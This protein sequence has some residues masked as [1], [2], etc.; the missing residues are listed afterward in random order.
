[1]NIYHVKMLIFNFL[2]NILVSPHNEN[3]LNNHYNVSLIQNHT[4]RTTIKSRL[5][6]QT[7]IHNPHYHND[8]ELKG[9][10]DKM[11]EEAI[12]KYQQTHDPYKQLKEVVEKN[13]SQN[14]SGHVA[15]PMSTIE[16]DLLEKYEDVFGDKNHAMLKSGRYPNDDDESDD[17]SSCDCTD[18]NNAK[19]EKTKGRDKYLKHLKHRCI[20]G[21]GFCSIGSTLLTLIGLALA[22]K[23]AFDVLNVTVGTLSF[24]EC[25]SSITIYN[26]LSSE[27]MLAGGSACVSDLTGTAASYATAIF[28]PCGITALVL[29]I[30]AVVLIILYIWLYRR[31]KRSWKH[32]CKKHLCK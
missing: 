15:E 22:K 9:I 7:Q 32:E 17:S 18:I 23:A 6:A 3:Y 29:L 31:R 28:D 1:M 20:H 16:K 13:G 24:K 5:L 27:S 30:L 10:I 25:A 21:I 26:M 19:L 11:N 2:I 8:P 14:R 4:K 12:K